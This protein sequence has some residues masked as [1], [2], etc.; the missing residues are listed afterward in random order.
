MSYSLDLDNMVQ[1]MAAFIVEPISPENLH[2]VNFV[3]C[4]WNCIQD[5]N[6]LFGDF[7]S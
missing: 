5:T 3:K 6:L 1:I 4:R 7:Y 2:I